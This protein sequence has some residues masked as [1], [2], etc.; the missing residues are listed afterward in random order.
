MKT[1]NQTGVSKF[2]L[3]GVLFSTFAF[4]LMVH[5]SA[6]LSQFSSTDLGRLF[7]AVYHIGLTVLLTAMLLLCTFFF[8]RER[9]R[10]AKKEQEAC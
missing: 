10:Q 9:K 1:E 5:L 7:A 6:G 2:E 3:Y 4:I 8:V